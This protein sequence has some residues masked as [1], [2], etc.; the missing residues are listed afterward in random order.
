WPSRMRAAATVG[1]LMPSPTNRITFFAFP[2]SAPRW[3]ASAAPSRNHHCALS[4]S[5]CWMVGTATWMA[6]VLAG[7]TGDVFDGAVVAQAATSRAGARTRLADR[8]GKCGRMDSGPGSGGT[9]HYDAQLLHQLDRFVPLMWSPLV[10][11]S[12]IV[13]FDPQLAT[14]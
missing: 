12:A 14:R 3:A 11:R 9:E 13:L 2:P 4:C 1:R 10:R 5:G 6:V 8:S 7:S